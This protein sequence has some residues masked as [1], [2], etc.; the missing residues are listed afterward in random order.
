MLIVLVIIGHWLEYGLG[1]SMNR[2][3][4]NFIY[5]FHMPMFIFISGYFSK[6]KDRDTFVRDIL[7]LME[8]YIIVQLL[9]VITSF[10]LQN[11]SFVIQQLYIP[12]A[13]AWFLLSLISWRVILQLLPS[14]FLDGKWILPVAIC[15]SLLAG[16]IPVENELSL[17]RTLAFLPFFICGYRMRGVLEFGQSPKWQKS[18]LVEALVLVLVLSILF[19]NRDISYIIYCKSN[20][21]THPH[22]ALVLMGLRALYI[23]IACFLVWCIFAVFPKVSKPNIL[24]RLGNDT[25]FYY[26]Y[27]II[28]MRAGIIFIRHFDLS[29]QLPAILCYTLFSV[30]TLYLLGKIKLLRWLLNPFSSININNK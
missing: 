11:K 19:L 18:L 16:F 30:V 4:F 1:N 21:Y 7:K 26:V 10:F 28:V 5:L 29:L 2:V 27:H 17:Q 20:Y 24:S 9:Y 14:T 3:V 25:M 8:T 22:S 12:N 15:I 23:I 6:K 13:A